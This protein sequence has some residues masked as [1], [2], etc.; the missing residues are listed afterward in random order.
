MK[1]ILN[2]I[3]TS[4]VPYGGLTTVA[5]NYYRNINHTSF[6]IDFASTN[7]CPQSLEEELRSNRSR[8]YK[9]PNRKKTPLSYVKALQTL[10]REY[11]V[12]HVH[13]NSATMI[14]ELLP[15]KKADVL[16]R[17]AHTH[18]NQTSHPVIHKM[19]YPAFKRTYT[20][21]IAVSKQ[22]GD[23]LYKKDYV[24]LNNAINIQKYSYSEKSRNKIRK[25]YGISDKT[26]VIGN[27]G[28]LNK[29]KN[30]AF[31]LNVFRKIKDLLSNSKLIIVG[32]GD[33]EKTLKAQA[34]KL[35]I[36]DD[37]IFT[38]MVDDASEYVQA[39][40]FF[41]F[42]SKFEGLGLALIEAQAAGLRCIISDKVPEEAIVTDQVK[43]L[44]IDGTDND[45]AK[46]IVEHKD[47]N[48][49]DNAKRAELTIREHGY[50]ITNEANKLEMI[51]MS[52]S[53]LQDGEED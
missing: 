31:L 43:V 33:L 21:A 15:A 36:G 24:I 1:K 28:K 2:V 29:P 3:T 14:L 26:Y 32:G 25:I 34:K 47:Y 5:M 17:I 30:H 10:C 7:D 22:A 44:G 20:R 16:V 12:I 35:E 4:Y 40:D 49:A 50:D 19:I 46:Y 13:G 45:W 37:V 9:L 42:P 52:D 11:D 39:F 27:I 48:R 6:K 8:Y 53:R 41:A 23:W 18:T 51:Y 38:G